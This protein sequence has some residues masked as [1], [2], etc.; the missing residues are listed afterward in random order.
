MYLLKSRNGKK[1]LAHDTLY[2]LK[3]DY[4]KLVGDYLSADGATFKVLDSG[5]IGQIKIKYKYKNCGAGVDGNGGI[6]KLGHYHIIFRVGKEKFFELKYNEVKEE[7]NL[8][9]FE[10]DNL[11]A[12]K[13]FKLK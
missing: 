3:E 9:I 4:S 11:K 7:I 12:S 5:K 8:M 6:V 10:Y 2:E 13:N 1:F